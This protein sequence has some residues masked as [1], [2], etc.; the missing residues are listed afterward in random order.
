M[1]PILALTLLGACAFAQQPKTF[2]S[3]EAAVQA[4]IDA[5]SKNDTQALAA[6]LG[7]NGQGL[8]TSGDPAR[9]QAERSQF[10]QLATAKHR[11]EHSSMR[12]D[13]MI[14]LVGDQQWPFPVP[15]MGK[16]Q[17]WHFDP[18]SGAIEVRARRIG[19]NELDAIEICAGYVEAQ[20][21]FAAERRSGAATMEY[22]RNIVSSAGHKD[23][24][25]APGAAPELVPEGF[26]NA[27][28]EGAR[29]A[30]PYH[31]YYFRVLREQGPNAPGGSHKYLAGKYMIGGFALEAWPAQYGVTG[32]H[33]FIVNQEGAV[34]EKDLGAATA[35]AARTITRYD[36]DSSW[37]PVD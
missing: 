5:S 8:L 32:V 15:L 31:G 16:D 13:T 17:S 4:L 24:L 30:K 23:G 37:T 33:T 34:Y 9:D 18:A 2:D 35:T 28:V 27:A 25:Y 21:A 19:A 26:A 6:V 29:A 7:S 3:P 20:Q 10:A 12:A 14:L 1:K 22:A 36:P 11:L